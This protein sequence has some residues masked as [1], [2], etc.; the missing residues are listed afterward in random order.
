V[1]GGLSGLPNWLMKNAPGVSLRDARGHVLVV[2]G[3]ALADVG[4]RQH[5]LGA[6]RLEVE[7]LLAAHLVG[8]DEDEL[9]ALLLRDQRQAE[10]GVAGG[11]LDQ[12]SPGLM[13]PR[14]RPPRSSTA[15]MRSLIEPPGFWLSSLRNSVQGRCRGAGLTIG[16]SPISSST[17][18]R[19]IMARDATA[20]G[21]D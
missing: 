3:M 14:A 19:A 8:H 10:A 6:H 11:A 7:D 9:V 2:V 17:A 16:V 15:P 13:S 1:R 4:A 5:D 21:T 12:V 20:G 18:E